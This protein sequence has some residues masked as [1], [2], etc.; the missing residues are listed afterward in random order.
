MRQPALVSIDTFG[1]GSRGTNRGNEG[2]MIDLPYA[3]A[4]EMRDIRDLRGFVFMC[5][6]VCINIEEFAIILGLRCREGK[7]F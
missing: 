2:D 1:I 7:C 6:C 4:L 3:T 5:H